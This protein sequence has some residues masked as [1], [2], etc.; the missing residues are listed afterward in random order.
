MV[1]GDGSTAQFIEYLFKL[2]ATGT[3]IE[4]PREADIGDYVEGGADV[5][6]VDLGPELVLLVVGK[7][8]D[9]DVGEDM[10]R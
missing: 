6:R 7:F 8:T 9:E 4:F 10:V 1:L 3:M 5:V 2:N